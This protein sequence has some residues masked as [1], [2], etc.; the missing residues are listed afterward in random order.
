M[1]AA[2]FR[3][4]PGSLLLRMAVLGDSFEVALAAVTTPAKS[5]TYLWHGMLAQLIT[6]LRVTN[7]A[8]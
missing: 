3:S 8:N 5:I 1:L 4:D 2:Y 7:A 6:S